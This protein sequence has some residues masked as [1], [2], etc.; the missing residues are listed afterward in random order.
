MAQRNQT[1][2]KSSSIATS[3]VLLVLAA[4]SGA[5]VLWL[6]E[7][8]RPQATLVSRSP[9][10]PAQPVPVPT[11]EIAMAPSSAQFQVVLAEIKAEALSKGIAASIVDPALQGLELDAEVLDL[12][13]TQ[14]EHVK[15]AGEYITLLVS[16]ARLEV[17][18]QKLIEHDAA[19]RAIEA[20]YGVDRHVVLAIWGV[21]SNY[22]GSMG[23]RRIV[24]SLATLAAFDKRR[25]VFWRAEL[26]AALRIL[27]SGDTTAANL[28]GS[29]AGA[30]GHTQ[31][32]P[33]TY[34]AHAV[35][36]DQ[37]GRRDIWSSIPDALAST[38]N[39]LKVSGW[40]AGNVWGVEV[41]L[42][43]TFDFGLASPSVVKTMTQWHGLGVELVPAQRLLPSPP[44]SDT[45]GVQLLLP[46]GA[47]GPSF[48]ISTNFNAILRYNNAMS[49]ALAVGHLADRLAGGA[50]IRT[51]WPITDRGLKSSEREELQRRLTAL[52]FATGGVDGVIGGGT[53]AAVRLFQKARGIPAD[54]YADL[55][56]LER[57]RQEG[58]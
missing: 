35:D 31:F 26:L 50:A 8:Q 37:D 10:V 33:T 29:W 16:D 49:Y 5:G 13:G 34:A 43:D 58:S 23:S 11:K 12:A 40:V 3:I 6:M 21:E 48:L 32:M 51:P 57:L 47:R 20:A 55:A 27:Q 53:K 42:P 39:Y 7:Q 17:G 19:L 45:D 30:M 1:H 24:R 22:G 46:A 44:F 18:R 52:G 9:V 36:F 28:A 54:G 15:T 41:V 2:R 4:L 14:P 56:L 25:P 38:A